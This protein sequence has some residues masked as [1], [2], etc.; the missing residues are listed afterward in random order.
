MM[1]GLYAIFWLLTG[2]DAVAT[3]TSAWREQ[4][5]LLERHKDMRP[6][7]W[8]ILF[9]LTDFALGAGWIVVPLAVPVALMSR[10]RLAQ[11][12]GETMP[13]DLPLVLLLCLALPALV[14]VLAL[15]QSETARVWNFMLPLLLFPAALELSRWPA[16]P[17][18]GV[19]ACMLVIL[20]VVGRHMRFMGP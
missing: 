9:D 14:A 20:L 2:F 18:R 17:R 8:T 11:R 10:R 6:Y 19:Y 16:W 7:P 3:F 13:H 5:R 4:H 15:L 1:V 12:F